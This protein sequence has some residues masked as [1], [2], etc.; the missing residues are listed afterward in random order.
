MAKIKQNNFLDTVDEVFAG[1][2]KEGVLHLYDE[3]E[4]LNGRTF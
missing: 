1:S 2:K 3:E 4:Y